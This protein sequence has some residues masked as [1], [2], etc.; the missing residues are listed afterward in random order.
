MLEV[1]E[2]DLGRI[3]ASAQ[4]AILPSYYIYGA[5]L[6]YIYI[7]IDFLF[8]VSFGGALGVIVVPLFSSM[9]RQGLQP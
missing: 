5:F 4:A 6:L 2:N 7:H 8:R 1:Y 3:A 9:R